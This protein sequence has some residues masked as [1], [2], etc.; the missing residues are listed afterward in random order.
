[1]SRW[2]WDVLCMNELCSFPVAT[3]LSKI[4][5]KQS[6]HIWSPTN[7]VFLR[8]STTDF[9]RASLSAV[10][11][12]WAFKKKKTVLIK[13]SFAFCT[14]ALYDQLNSFLEF[15]TSKRWA[16]ILVTSGVDSAPFDCEKKLWHAFAKVE[17]IC[18]RWTERQI[19]R[20]TFIFGDLKSSMHHNAG[21]GGT[22]PAHLKVEHGNSTS[23]AG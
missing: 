23:E 15:K 4:A 12:N 18:H 22:S 7:T 3:S 11:Y 5:M 17:C 10:M 2:S 9:P 20:W 16:K 8:P 13:A 1:M 6:I 21:E 14:G 19:W